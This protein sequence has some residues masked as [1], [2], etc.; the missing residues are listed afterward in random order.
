[1]Q[2]AAFEVNSFHQVRYLTHLTIYDLIFSI[3]RRA[4][5]L[6]KI[7]SSVSTKAVTPA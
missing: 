1:M 7:R 4:A 2:T 5:R 3:Q 6:T